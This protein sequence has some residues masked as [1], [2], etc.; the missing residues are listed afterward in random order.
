MKHLIIAF[1]IVFSFKPVFSD[2]LNCSMSGQDTAFNITRSPLKDLFAFSVLPL[3]TSVNSSRKELC[4][5]L[6]KILKE[7]LGLLGN[8]KEMSTNDPTGLGLSGVFLSFDIQKVENVNK[9]EEKL[10][11][12]SL[13]VPTIVT[14]KKSNN[15][16]TSYIWASSVFAE[17]DTDE[18]IKQG[19]EALL[20]QFSICYQKANSKEA[21]KPT[22]YIYQ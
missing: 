20:K 18:N 17:S 19:I 14:I 21:E 4:D 12:L 11:R 15:E 8:V 22:F 10:I 13:S 6:N 16:C 2:D 1:F 3:V 9:K 5:T 7:K